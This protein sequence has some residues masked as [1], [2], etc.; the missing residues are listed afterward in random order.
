MP[1]HINILY[2]ILY[3]YWHTNNLVSAILAMLLYE[4]Q[5]AWYINLHT[6]TNIQFTIHDP[7]KLVHRE[8]RDMPHIQ[9]D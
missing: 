8:L 3:I 4:L 2:Y 1:A 6:N 9:N 7:S 5:E